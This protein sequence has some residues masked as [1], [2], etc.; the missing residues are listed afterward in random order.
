MQRFNG[1]EIPQAPLLLKPP[2]RPVD[3]MVVRADGVQ[4]NPGEG[5]GFY[6]YDNGQWIKLG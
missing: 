5:R 2:A 1:W 4:W 3:D 6:G